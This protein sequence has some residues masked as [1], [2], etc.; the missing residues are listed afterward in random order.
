[1]LRHNEESGKAVVLR[2]HVAAVH[3]VSPLTLKEK[4][5]ANLLLENAMRNSDDGGSMTS[6]SI[7]MPDLAEDLM[8]TRKNR[9]RLKRALNGLLKKRVEWAYTNKDYQREWGA[10]S[11]LAGY[12]FNGTTLEYSYSEQLADKL[13]KPAVWAR[14]NLSIQVQLT[15][16]HSQ[17]LYENCVRYRGTGRTMIWDLETFRK[18]MGVDGHSIYQQ[19]K[20]LNRKVIKPSVESINAFTEIEVEPTIYREGKRVKR[21]GFLVRE[22]VNYEGPNI[23][24]ADLTGRD[25]DP[26]GIEDRPET[27]SAMM[28]FGIDP[29]QAVALL[30]DYEDDQILDNLRLV[31]SRL[32]DKPGKIKNVGGY[33]IN[34]IRRDYRAE[35]LDLQA[36][37]DFSTPEEK[38]RDEADRIKREA[39]AEVADF[40]SDYKDWRVDRWLSSVDESVVSEHF[41]EFMESMAVKYPTMKK[42]LSNPNHKGTVAMWREW[43]REHILPAP[44][45]TERLSFAKESGF[46]LNE[47]RVAAGEAPLVG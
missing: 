22:N 27:F 14:I 1:M 24:N 30:R 34:A 42:I 10:S 13:V 28:K 38:A 46:P 20:E 5:M 41:E 2:K 45:D 33:A 25:V 18:L 17:A 37:M 19:Y 16:L 40:E 35:H 29:T 21:I 3:V 43:I 32:R 26:K 39:A 31:S 12:H 6:H 36:A 4:Q 11:W 7:Y 23:P 44:S 47:T 9:D 8:G 15:S